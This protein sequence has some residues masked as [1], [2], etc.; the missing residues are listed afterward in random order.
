MNS[1]QL[2]STVLIVGL[3]LLPTII[4]SLI[5]GPRDWEPEEQYDYR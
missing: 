5:S 3:A 4:A 1:S 2:A